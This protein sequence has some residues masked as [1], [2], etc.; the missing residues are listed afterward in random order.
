MILG[1]CILQSAKSG[2]LLQKFDNVLSKL[3]MAKLLQISSVGPAVN[4]KFLREMNE[5][6]A[7]LYAQPLVDIGT[8]GLHPIYGS[9]KNGLLASED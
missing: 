2:N 8:C 1:P 5:K 4:L 3:D 9:F 7:E 6:R